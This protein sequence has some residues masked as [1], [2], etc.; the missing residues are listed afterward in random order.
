MQEGLLVE[1][2]GRKPSLRHRKE[3][4]QTDPNANELHFVLPPI[5]SLNDSLDVEVV[6]KRKD[7]A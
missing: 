6:E 4:L 1:K 7:K 2:V 5:F 3:S